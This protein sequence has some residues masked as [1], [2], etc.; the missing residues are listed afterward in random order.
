MEVMDVVR[1]LSDMIEDEIEDSEKYLTHAIE[2]KDDMPE[3]ARL[4]YALSEEEMGHMHRLFDEMTGIVTR[5]RAS[6][7]DQLGS[8]IR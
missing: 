3:L 1:A 8:L 2:R 7:I 4:F 6:E 5:Y